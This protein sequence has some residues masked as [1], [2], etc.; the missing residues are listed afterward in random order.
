ML[1]IDFEVFAY[2]WLMVAMDSSREMT[3][4]VIINDRAAL[5]EFYNAN[6]HDLFV[7]FN[8]RHY[9]QWI[10]KAIISDFP[11][12]EVNDHIIGKK[13]PGWKYSN[14]LNYVKLNVYD[15][16]TNIDPG[17]KKFEG[18][19]G[20]DIRESSVPFDINRKLTDAEL[21]EVVNYCRHDVQELIEVFIRRV[22]TFDAHYGLVKLICGDGTLDLS[23]MGK[24]G[25][26]LSAKLLG[27]EKRH[28]DD[29]F[30]ID[31]PH[32]LQVK[33]Y[34]AVLDWYMDERNRAYYETRT[35][36]RGQSLKPV[37]R[38]L[39]MIVAGV[40]HQFGYGGVHGA[41]EKYTASGHFLMMDV[42]S[43]Y[44]SLMIQYGLLS[45]S[46]KDAS[47][48]EE[49][50]K[51][52][53]ELKKQRDPL[54]DSL[55]LV[56]NSTYGVMKDQSNGLY[57]P[58]QANRVCIYGQLLILDLIERI[59]GVA[60][61]VQ[62]NTDG[63]LIR[64]PDNYPGGCDAWYGRIDD[65]AFEWEQRTMLTLEFEEYSRVYQK[66]VNNYIVVKES[67]EY[68]S[69]GAYV[70]KLSDLDNDLPIVNKA[71]VN[72]LVWRVPVEKTING[73]ETLKDFQMICRITA[74]YDAI[75]HGEKRLNERCVRAFAS[76]CNDDQ[77]LQKVHGE[78]G[79]PAKVPN[80]P[81]RCFIHNNDVNGLL[82]PQKLDKEFYI[83]MAIER[84]KDFGVNAQ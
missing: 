7:G 42:A 74:K 47:S 5:N 29:E 18:F 75:L 30:N 57:D 4:T 44:P 41:I 58:R 61:L 33:K 3:E 55:K 28:Y 60:E 43:L 73:S 67:G 68:K 63:I 53:L 51:K 8:I 52:R 24:T 71:V 11:P 56:L 65:I 80:T 23:L 13:L 9:D 40:P 83:N 54:A 16:M 77:G 35:G 6:K 37:R 17:L 20:H 22:S 48:Y 14:V 21:D 78:T 34:T 84:L 10:F 36:K 82:V 72:Y 46:V 76:T 31:F 49:I 26:Q 81:A 39:N 70:K 62:S 32:T 79:R 38:Q 27:A 19:L 12:K 64:M 45:R 25:P 50:F 2:D 59:E 69:K 15:V 1:F 66:D